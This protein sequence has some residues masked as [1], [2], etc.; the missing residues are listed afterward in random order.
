MNTGSSRK[1]PARPLSSLTF[2]VDISMPCI[3]RMSSTVKGRLAAPISMAA[4]IART[5]P[6]T[7]RAS[8]YL[9]PG[10]ACSASASF[11]WEIL[12]ASIHDDATA[13]ERIRLRVRLSSPDSLT[14]LS[15]PNKRSFGV[16][17]VG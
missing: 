9:L 3:E 14:L 17:N 5:L 6:R 4:A 2:D 7:R 8:S 15:Q 13:S 12:S 16:R 1:R 10:D 11:R